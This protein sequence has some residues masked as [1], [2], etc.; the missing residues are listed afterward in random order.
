MMLSRREMYYGVDYRPHTVQ[1]DALGASRD[2]LGG[3]GTGR[4][5]L[6]VW[7]STPAIDTRFV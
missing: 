6:S 3:S 7:I 1:R 2:G 4:S 5:R